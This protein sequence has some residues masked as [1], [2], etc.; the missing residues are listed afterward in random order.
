M[1]DKKLN[2]H[3]IAHERKNECVIPSG[4]RNLTVEASV[5]L[6]EIA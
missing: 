5:T 4:A 6:C 2:P 3:L 1:L